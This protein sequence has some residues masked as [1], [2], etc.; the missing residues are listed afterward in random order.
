MFVKADVNVFFF[1][2]KLNF[3]WLLE[4]VLWFLREVCM[5]S[6]WPKLSAGFRWWIK[7]ISKMPVRE[8]K[9]SMLGVSMMVSSWAWFTGHKISRM[10]QKIQDWRTPEVFWIRGLRFAGPMKTSRQNSLEMDD[11]MIYW[12]FLMWRKNCRMRFWIVLWNTCCYMH[13]ANKEPC[14]FVLVRSC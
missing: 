12:V 13:F 14:S 1:F 3:P 6:A 10:S 11:I 2:L 9:G 8:V 4:V 7:Q 5:G